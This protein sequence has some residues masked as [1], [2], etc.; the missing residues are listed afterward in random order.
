MTHGDGQTHEINM[1][2][3]LFQIA[4]I[5]IFARSAFIPLSSCFI[6]KISLKPQQF[7]LLDAL[8][9]RYCT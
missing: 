2:F 5:L 4:Q 3:M 7:L 1:P 6:A 8:R 9:D